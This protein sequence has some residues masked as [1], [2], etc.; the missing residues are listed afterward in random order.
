[1]KLYIRFLCCKMQLTLNTME[2]RGADPP[3]ESQKPA[4]NF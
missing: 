3:P 1:M 4:Y 2:V